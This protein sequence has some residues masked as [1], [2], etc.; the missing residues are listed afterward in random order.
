[1]WKSINR[2][3]AC[4]KNFAGAMLKKDRCQ[5]M[6]KIMNVPNAE[7]K[8]LKAQLKLAKQDVTKLKKENF[9]F[10]TLLVVLSL[11][12]VM[13]ACM[14]FGNLKVKDVMSLP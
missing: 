3:G 13:L 11:F 5:P 2:Q 9:K 7:I 14:L 12:I 10:K 4:Q 8:A 6:T 1:M